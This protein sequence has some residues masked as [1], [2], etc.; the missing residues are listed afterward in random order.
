MAPD[1]LV[2]QGL[3]CRLRLSVPGL[4]EKRPSII[5]GDR[6]LVQKKGS[7]N[8]G[9][10]YEGLV[11]HVRLTEVDLK[12]DS[13]F[14]GYKGQKYNVRFK[15]GRIPLRRMHQALGTAFKA[16]RVLFPRKDHVKGRKAPTDMQMEDI[17]A[18]NRIIQTNPPQLLAV[19][20][21]L[22]MPEGSVPF[23]LFGPCVS[24]IRQSQ[25]R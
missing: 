13:L 19:A 15:V 20:T 16:D 7:R 2:A 5:V 1:P 17:R 21:I 4:A 3:I 18:V 25:R 22:H 9:R 12:F 23:V 14:N 6:I 24:R 8:P 10:W 11:H